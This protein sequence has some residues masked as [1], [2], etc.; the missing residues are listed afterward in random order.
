M[1]TLVLNNNNVV[2]NGQNNTLIYRFPTTAHFKNSY[3]AVASVSMYYAWFN[4]AS[5]Y[6]NTNFSY[7]WVDG[8]VV[9]VT[10]PDGLYEVSTL[11]QFLQFEMIKNRHYLI[12][13]GTGQNIYFLEILVNDARYKVQVNQ[14]VVPTLAIYTASLT[15]LYDEPPGGLNGFSPVSVV[16]V[17]YPGINFGYNGSTLGAILGFVTNSNVAS[18]TLAI[19]SPWTFSAATPTAFSS[20]TPNIQPNS[21]VLVSVSSVDNPY[22]SPTSVIYSVTPSVAVGTIIADKPPQLLWNK[23]IP[24]N[25]AQITVTLLGTDLRPLPIQ[26]GAMTIIL[27]IAEEVEALGVVIDRK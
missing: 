16:N 11:N 14:F 13:K 21:S 3:V 22:A 18:A 7:T 25:Y 10:I 19:P 17:V 9:P 5:I 12:D 20:T 23:L 8:T 27:A 6:G 4:I 1:R 2:N 26:D 15:T 24:G